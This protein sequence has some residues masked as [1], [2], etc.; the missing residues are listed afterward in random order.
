MTGKP[1]PL[2]RTGGNWEEFQ[3]EAERRSWRCA[4]RPL[5]CARMERMEEPWIRT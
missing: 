2:N 1:I 3:S 4:R 5:V